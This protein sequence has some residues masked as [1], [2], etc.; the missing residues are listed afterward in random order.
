MLC[1]VESCLTQTSLDV[2]GQAVD[3]VLVVLV[4]V[5]LHELHQTPD[6]MVKVNS[7]W[8]IRELYHRAIIVTSYLAI[9]SF[10]LNATC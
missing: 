1:V 6:F 10:D 3:V 8:S 4:A 9:P 2:W 5:V 7:L